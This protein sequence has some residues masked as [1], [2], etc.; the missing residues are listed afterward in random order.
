MKNRLRIASALVIGFPKVVHKLSRDEQA[1][2]SVRSKRPRNRTSGRHRGARWQPQALEMAEP[3]WKQTKLSLERPYRDDHGER[4][5]VLLDITPG[6]EQVFES[7]AVMLSFATFLLIGY[8]SENLTK[9]LGENLRRIFVERGLDFF[10]RQD[11]LRS[12]GELLVAQPLETTEHL[13]ED[14]E[15]A[16]GK[17]TRASLTPEELFNMRKECIPQ[18]L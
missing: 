17:T 3:A 7:Y 18:L 2:V 13:D 8:S 10:E 12:G 5:P 14:E 9:L 15:A 11:D 6:G 16:V 1:W 4:I